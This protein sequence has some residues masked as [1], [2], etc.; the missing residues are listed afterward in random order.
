MKFWRKLLS[1]WWWL[2]NSVFLSQPFCKKN[3]KKYF[4]FASNLLKLVIGYGTPRMGQNF[5]D[6]ADFQKKT[7][8]GIK[9]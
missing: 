6:C 7:R 2:K 8:G 3:T 9:L 1:F 5:H 4:L